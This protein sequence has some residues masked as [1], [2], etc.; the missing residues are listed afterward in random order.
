VAAEITTTSV[1][2][3][4]MVREALK[5]ISGRRN[6]LLSNAFYYDGQRNMS[7]E[8]EISLDSDCPVHTKK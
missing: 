4:I 1:I 3:A 5:Y 6:M 8:I 7:E 2:S